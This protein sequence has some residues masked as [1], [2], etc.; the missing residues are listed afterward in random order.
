MKKTLFVLLALS[1]C[2]SC[3]KEIVLSGLDVDKTAFAAHDEFKDNASELFASKLTYSL[4]DGVYYFKYTLDAAKSDYMNVRLLLSP[5]KNM[6]FPFGYDSSYSLV[7]QKDQTNE[8]KNI[9][10][11]IV[12][13]FYSTAKLEKIFCYFHSDNNDLYYMQ[14]ALEA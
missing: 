12:V 2:I 7:S 14:N 11:G 10:Y 4:N 13:N 5:D 1:L 9:Y 8:K 6:F 3:K